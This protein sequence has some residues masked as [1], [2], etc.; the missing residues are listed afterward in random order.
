MADLET[1]M[2]RL[3]DSLQKFNDEDLLAVFSMVPW[4]R[5]SLHTYISNHQV[6]MEKQVLARMEALLTAAA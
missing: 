5:E 4:A 1:L 2:M 3:D 6:E